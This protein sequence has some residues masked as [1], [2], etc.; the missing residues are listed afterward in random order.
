MTRKQRDRRLAR[1]CGVTLIGASLVAPAAAQADIKWNRGGVE[2]TAE[3]GRGGKSLGGALF[4]GCDGAE[5]M[6]VALTVTQGKARGTTVFDRACTGAQE[7]FAFVVDADKH[8]FKR[9]PARV[10]GT[11]SDAESSISR[12]TEITLER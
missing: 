11:L 6:R 10:C 2:P 9:G 12:C 3:L 5:L 7:R 1:A 4:A 8:H